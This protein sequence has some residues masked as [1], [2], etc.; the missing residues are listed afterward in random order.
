M[1]NAPIAMLG[2][3][4]PVIDDTPPPTGWITRPA[5]HC[6][7]DN[8]RSWDGSLPARGGTHD[9]P[10]G[11]PWSLPRCPIEGDAP[12]GP[13]APR[14]QLGRAQAQ[15][16]PRRPS[17]ARSGLPPAARATRSRPAGDTPPAATAS[18]AA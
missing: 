3:P 9:Y 17:P 7:F 13:R 10:S 8:L 5:A 18:P 1:N 12:I 15:V 16:R 11:S 2:P 4:V 14:D 6:R